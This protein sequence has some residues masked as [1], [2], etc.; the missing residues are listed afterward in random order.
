MSI[1]KAAKTPWLMTAPGVI[2]FLALLGAPMVMTLLL[3][4]H[5]YDFNLGVL[6]EWTLAQYVDVL[7]DSY[8]HKIFL[9]TFGLAALVTVICVLIGAPEAYVLS[10]LRNPWRSIFLLSLCPEQ[11]SGN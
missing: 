7:G 3:S 4:L 2:F 9:R 10:R 11:S 5:A 6:P 1:V 8:F